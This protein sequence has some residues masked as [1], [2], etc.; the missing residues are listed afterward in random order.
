[1]SAVVLINKHIEDKDNRLRS[2]IRDK[3]GAL[4][5]NQND[6]DPLVTIE[7][8]LYD[9][10]MNN[11]T[12]KNFKRAKIPS[13]PSKSLWVD[14]DVP[15]EI[16]MYERALE[17]WKSSYG[18]V[19]SLWDLNWGDSNYHNSDDEGWQI[20]GMNFSGA[21]ENCIH[22][23]YIF[24]YRVALK[25]TAWYNY[26]TVPQAVS[27]AYE[28]FSSD[29]KSRISD[30]FEKGSYFRIW[31]KIYD[32]Q[33]EYYGIYIND[34]THSWLAGMHIPGASSPENGGPVGYMWMHNDYYRVYVAVSQYTNYG[35]FKH[36]WNPDI[37]ERNKLLLLWL[38]AIAVIFL[39]PIIVTSIRIIHNNNK[40]KTVSIKRE[41]LDK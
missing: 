24:P 36:G 30:R 22:I 13:K 10:P 21:D 27:E 7:D 31:S 14:T 6:D 11:A 35:I 25:K 41:I 4:F 32:C 1:M 20:V 18:D 5:V 3:I 39:T 9:S 29:S 16:E 26:Y 8:G 28:F 38:I 17:D 12:V 40:E 33:N 2:E 19:A 15:M 23:F 34:K 37:R